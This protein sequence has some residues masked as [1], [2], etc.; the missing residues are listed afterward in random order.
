MEKIVVGVDDSAA[1]RSALAWVV[2]R[3]G[4]RAAEV[5]IVHVGRTVSGRAAP[6]DDA[7]AHAERMLRAVAP[8]R[9][10]TYRRETGAVAPTLAAASVGA[11][12]L[13]IGVDPA[14]PVRAALGGWL[15]VRIISHV[16]PPVCVVPAGWVPRQGSIT[17]GLEDDPSSTDAVKFAAQEAER[18]SARL[19]IVHAW[20][21]PEPSTEGS[22]ALLARPRRILEQHRELL[23]A[24]VRSVAQGFPRV[25]VEADLVRAS[26]AAALLQHAPGAAMLVVGTHRDGPLVGAYV[27][28]VAH[29]LLGRAGCPVVVVPSA[30]FPARGA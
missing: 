20:H 28:S 15:P 17:V 13:V 3:C 29:D 6:S 14:H 16:R 9:R 7:L 11:D 8:G 19:R 1:S 23:E 5:D 22:A 18:S 2:D 12:L 27:G 26:P 21:L 4:A 24:V 30:G 10:A 25:P